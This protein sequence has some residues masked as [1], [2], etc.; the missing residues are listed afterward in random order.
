MLGTRQHERGVDLVA[1][2]AGTAAY[3]DVA[4]PLELGAREDAAPRVVR[5]GEDQRLRAVGEQPVEAVEVDLRTL[6]RGRHLEQVLG[7]SGDAG[8]RCWAL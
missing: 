2:D 7:A 1:H 6:R 3:D 4:D 5:L 8:Q